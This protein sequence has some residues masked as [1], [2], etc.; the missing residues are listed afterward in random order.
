[1]SSMGTL[2]GIEV[3]IVI[4]GYIVAYYVYRGVL[5]NEDIDASSDG[6][7]IARMFK[8]QLK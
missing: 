7:G 5:G 8:E 2:M 1:M 3:I 4:I 6:A